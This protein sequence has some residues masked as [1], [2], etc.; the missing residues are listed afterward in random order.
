MN[1]FEPSVRILDFIE[2]KKIVTWDC[3]DE[4]E[5]CEHCGKD[6]VEDEGL[7]GECIQREDEVDEL[8]NPDDIS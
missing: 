6:L 5:Y 3:A 1:E 8:K 2:I 7:C 4:L